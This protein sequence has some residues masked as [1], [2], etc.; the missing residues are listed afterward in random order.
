MFSE[1][2]SQDARA[3]KTKE[4]SRVSA[5]RRKFAD[6]WSR[7]RACAVYTRV[8]QSRLFVA[9]Q[10]R[11]LVGCEQRLGE[12]AGKLSQMI[13]DRIEEIV[14]GSLWAVRSRSRCELK[15]RGPA[16]RIFGV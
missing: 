5:L 13:S 4:A 1:S 8:R 14:S 6:G 7:T 9:A 3:G 15:K 12:I 16:Q 11:L 10:V 2:R